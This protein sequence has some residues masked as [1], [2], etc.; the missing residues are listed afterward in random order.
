MFSIF[1]Q[2]NMFPWINMFVTLLRSY[3]DSLKSLILP[4][5]EKYD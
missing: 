5:P 1:C 2:H 3:E 4:E